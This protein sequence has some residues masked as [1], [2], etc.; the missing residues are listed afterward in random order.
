[1]K[2][3]I[4]T[5]V[6]VAYVLAAPSQAQQ[7]SSPAQPQAAPCQPSQPPQPPKGMK[8]DLPKGLKQALDKQR[9]QIQNKTGLTIP[10]SDD[11]KQQVQQAA[12]SAPCLQPP[13]PKPLTPS[14]APPPAPVP[15]KPTYVCPPKATLIAN[16]PY[17]IYPDNTVVDAIPLPASGTVPA[18]PARI[19]AQTTTQQ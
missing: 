17:C 18:P 15:A 5:L 1:M 11:I 6:A 16:H 4:F 7:S 19:P 10:S 9:Q 13:A 3:S 12:A 2:T 8:F 14:P